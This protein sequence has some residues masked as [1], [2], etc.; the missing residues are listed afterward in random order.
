MQ[1]EICGKE[2][3]GEPATVKVEGSEFNVCRECEKYGVSVKRAPVAVKENASPVTFVSKQKAPKNYFAGLDKDIVEDYDVV[4][5]EAREK[6]GW[7]QEDLA[8][9]MK[10]K[11]HLIKKIER[12]EIMPEEA[13]IAKLEKILGIRLMES[14]DSV[15]GYKGNHSRETTLADIV[16]IKRK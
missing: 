13:I 6:K 9:N 3:R 12:K 15:D 10:E 1:C 7:S 4:I 14:A 8:H 16:S 5:K 11:A 2:I